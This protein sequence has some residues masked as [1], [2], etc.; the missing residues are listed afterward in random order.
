VAGIEADEV[1]CRAHV[2]GATAS[3]TALVESLGYEKAQA[4]AA[5]AH[6]EGKPLRAVVVDGGYLS[7]EQFDRLVSPD[8]VSRLGSPSPE[9]K[10]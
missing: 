1:R 9:E 8:S 6:F 5:Q 3:I 10:Q 2:N 7:Q 4:I